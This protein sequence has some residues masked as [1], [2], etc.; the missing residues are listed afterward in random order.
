MRTTLS[1]EDLVEQKNAIIPRVPE[2]TKPTH[3]AFPITEK[4]HLTSAIAQ[5]KHSSRQKTHNIVA[6]ASK[7]RKFHLL[8]TP[9]S[10]SSPFLNPKTLAQKHRKSRKKNLAVFVERIENNNRKANGTGDRSSRPVDS[11]GL[12]KTT[13]GV[14]VGKK[15]DTTSPLAT[16]RKRPNAT[17]A[18]RKWRTETWATNRPEKPN[19]VDDGNGRRTAENI[20]EPSSQWDYGSAKLAEQLQEVALEEMRASEERQRGLSGG[21]GTLKVKPKPPKPRRQARAEKVVEEDGSGD[22]DDDDDDVMTDTVY[23]DDIDD[24]D[25]GDYVLDTYVRSSAA[26]ASEPFGIIVTE[27]AESSEDHDSSL[28]N[29]SSII[30]HSNVGIL[31]IENEEE[32]ALWEAF[33]AEDEEESDPEWNSEEEDE[34]GN[35]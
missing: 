17:A 13:D 22:D 1:S 14:G 21:G 20:Y 5:P 23:L 3:D 16:P 11:A 25:D 26:A 2:I 18:E 31:V 30:D 24:D 12:L 33:F 28:H 34:N 7:A 4:R 27:A 19:E 15:E 32:E 8:N 35:C 10:I 6:S 29:S 9:S